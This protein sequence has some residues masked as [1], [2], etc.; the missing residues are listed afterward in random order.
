MR[1][2]N[3]L[4]KMFIVLLPLL[5]YSCAATH[6]PQGWLGSAVNLQNDPYGGWLTVKTTTKAKLAGEFIAIS[7]DSIFVANET[8]FAIAKSDIKSARLAVYNSNAG[9]MGG[10][11][12]L[13]TMATLSNGFFLVFTAPL[14]IIGGSAAAGARS[15]EPIVDHPKKEWE[16][17]CPICALS[18]GITIKN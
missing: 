2:H 14:W 12:A 8:F 1:N 6:A 3:I 5:C 11:T 18:A 10:L 9:A 17:L 7:D 16:P 13:G 15:F 4:Q